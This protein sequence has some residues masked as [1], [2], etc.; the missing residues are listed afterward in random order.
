MSD[1]FKFEFSLEV[2]NHLGRGLYRN[3]ITVLA[4]AVSNSWDSQANN[5]WINTD[6]NKEVLTILDDGVG[7]NRDDFQ[8]KFLTVGYARRL[9]KSNETKRAVI[10]RKGIGKLAMLSISDKVTILSKKKD[11]KLVGGIIDN[12]KLDREIEKNGKYELTGLENQ[13][14]EFNL[15][16]GTKIKFEG[17]KENIKKNSDNL[18]RK[19]LAIHF[20]FGF[21]H[22]KEKFDIF[23]NDEIIGDDDVKDFYKENEFIWI[24]GDKDSRTNKFKDLKEKRQITDNKFGNHYIRGYVSS[25]TKPSYLKIKGSSKNPGEEFRISVNLFSNGRLRE[26]NI[27]KDI[28]SS[29]HLYQYVYGEIHVDSFDQYKDDLFTSSREGIKKDNEF[30]KS[31]AKKLRKIMHGINKEW[32]MSRREHRTDGDP[33]NRSIPKFERKLEES[34]NAREDDFKKKIDSIDLPD[35]TKKTLK[36]KLRDLSSKNTK[37]YQDLFILE[38]LYREYIKKTYTEEQLKNKVK[39]T[40]DSE[41][42][43]A[44]KTLVS[45]DLTKSKREQDQCRHSLKGNITKTENYLNYG[46]IVDLGILVDFINGKGRVKKQDPQAHMADSKEIRPIRNVIMHTNEVTDAVVDWKKIKNVIDYIEELES[47]QSRKA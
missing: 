8:D 15:E 12:K 6:R 39:S 16:S 30:Y 10:G 46:D 43:P 40:Q 5:V 22:P 11:D 2:L 44:Q 38:N 19:Q 9:D 18:I 41:A 42:E 28:E 17:F 1:K 26:Q 7:M 4:E 35:D 31:F 20:N 36:D 34:K 13:N 32:D 24:I 47:R 21:S 23:F 33:E 3:F 27:L 45:M 29:T 37:I 25:V 14:G